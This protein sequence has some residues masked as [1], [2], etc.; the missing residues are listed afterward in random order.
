MALLPVISPFG[1]GTPPVVKDAGEITATK[2][3]GS[4]KSEGGEKKTLAPQESPSSLLTPPEGY[5]KLFFDLRPSSSS[6]L[7]LEDL[8]FSSHT[9]NGLLSRLR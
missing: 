1:Y 7:S 2:H 9:L 3:V 8:I 5:A 6:M 4:A